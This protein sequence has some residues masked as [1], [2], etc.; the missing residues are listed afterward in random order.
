MV[1]YLRIV[2]EVH[3]RNKERKIPYSRG[4][5]CIISREKENSNILEN[6]QKQQATTNTSY[7][8]MF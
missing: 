3:H 6:A 8:G 1:V 4:G 5:V 7:Q 2:G